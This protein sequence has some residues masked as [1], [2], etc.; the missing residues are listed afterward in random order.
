MANG[1]RNNFDAGRHARPTPS[2]MAGSWARP[3]PASAEPPETRGQATGLG[4][5]PG[6]GRHPVNRSARRAGPEGA[7]PT[8][9]RLASMNSRHA[10]PGQPPRIG[11]SRTPVPGRRHRLPGNVP[12]PGHT[13]LLEPGPVGGA[14]PQPPRQNPHERRARGRARYGPRPAQHTRQA[15]EPS[16]TPDGRAGRTPHPGTRATREPPSNTRHAHRLIGT[17]HPTGAQAGRL[18]S[19]TR[20]VREPSLWRTPDRGAG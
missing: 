4:Q 13:P 6:S 9:R 11:T 15:P 19:G 8:S 20:A 3:V 16:A 2:G 18:T 5:L 17:A 10:R 12:G 1:R 14:I 7:C